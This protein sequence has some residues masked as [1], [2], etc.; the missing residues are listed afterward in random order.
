MAK[1]VH[2]NAETARVG[3]ADHQSARKLADSQ[4]SAALIYGGQWS[5]PGPVAATGCR[6]SLPG[7]CIHGAKMGRLWGR[8]DEY[9]F[10]CDERAANGVAEHAAVFRGAGIDFVDCSRPD[11]AEESCGAGG[12]GL[13]G[14]RRVMHRE[15]GCPLLPPVQREIR[16]AE[17]AGKQFIRK[18]GGESYGESAAAIPRV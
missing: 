10:F 5:S 11:T 18:K 14:R 12:L 17:R 7:D 16:R 13:R 3:N 1:T 15:A 8:R 4:T 9:A 6:L 2:M